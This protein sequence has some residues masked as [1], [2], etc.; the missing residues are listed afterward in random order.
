MERILRRTLR[1]GEPAQAHASCLDP[2]TLAAWADGALQGDEVASLEAHAAGCAR[3]QGMLAAM[4][5]TPPAPTA[6]RRSW[7]SFL[8]PVAMPLGAAAAIAII[9]SVVVFRQ[10]SAPLEE[11]RQAAAPAAAAAD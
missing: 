7:R 8:V 5:R 11:T 2:E 9:V 4:A 6:P 3:C 10:D 1:A